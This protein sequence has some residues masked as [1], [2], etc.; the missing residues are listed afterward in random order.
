MKNKTVIRVLAL[1]LLCALLPAAAFAEEEEEYYF[2]NIYPVDVDALKALEQED[3]FE[4]RVTRKVVTDGVSSSMS[5]GNRDMLSLTVEN[6]SGET[7]TSVI[8]LAVAYDGDNDST[9][10]KEPGYGIV[11]YSG[12][13]KRQVSTLIFNDVS[14]APGGSTVLNTPCNHRNFTGVRVLVAQYTD[15]DGEE[16]TNPLYEEWQELALGSPTIYLD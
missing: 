3:P 12:R 5:D 8:I 10:L 2:F 15:E 4:L 14:I 11:A 9:E 16:H 7:V 13:A 1:L 6:T